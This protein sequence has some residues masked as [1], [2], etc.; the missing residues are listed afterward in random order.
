MDA[1][2]CRAWESCRTHVRNAA[3]YALLSFVQEMLRGTNPTSGGPR[4]T[5]RVKTGDE[6]RARKNGE[7]AG[8]AS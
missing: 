7:E 4:P 1:S 8:S 3:V 5:A 2:H 6:K